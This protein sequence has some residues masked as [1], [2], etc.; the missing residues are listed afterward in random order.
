MPGSDPRPHLL[1]GVPAREGRWPAE[2]SW[3]AGLGRPATG[4]EVCSSTPSGTL[5]GLPRPLLL[6]CPQGT[7]GAPRQ[8][9]C[10]GVLPLS[11]LRHASGAEGVLT[12]DLC[13][14]RAHPPLWFVTEVGYVARHREA[15]GGGA[16][17]PALSL[18]PSGRPQGQ[19]SPH[20]CVQGPPGHTRVRT[21]SP[22]GRAPPP[23]ALWPQF[24][25][26]C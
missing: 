23:G 6:P 14:E 16:P 11:A 13:G 24:W 8:W 1:Q 4:Q 7:C 25:A 21:C 2:R 9:P 26:R 17:P 22:T 15:M 12:R 18:P 20:S 10:R 19:R 5:A 3:G